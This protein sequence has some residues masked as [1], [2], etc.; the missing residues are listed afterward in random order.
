MKRLLLVCVLL[1]TAACGA[2]ETPTPTVAP[3]P[4]LPASTPNQV[5]LLL[6]DPFTDQDV[7][8][9]FDVPTGWEIT[10]G[11]SNARIVVIP[12]L[13]PLGE[14]NPSPAESVSQSVGVAAETVTV[15]G[16]EV[17]VALGGTAPNAPLSLAVTL[18][19]RNYFLQINV[20]SI[21]EGAPQDYRE[22]LQQIILSARLSE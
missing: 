8:V 13:K 20:L 11:L 4:N 5:T 1:F 21:F 22:A 14:G 15:D 19:N 10:A 2:P 7:S 17:F 9:I 6:S 18:P 3:T 12:T 16:R